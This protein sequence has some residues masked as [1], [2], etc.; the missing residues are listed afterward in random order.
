MDY[1]NAEEAW[2]ALHSLRSNLLLRCG[3]YSALTIPK[4]LLPEGLDLMST[5]QSTD[6][7]SMGARCVNHLTN[8]L[9]TTMFSPSRPFFRAGAGKKTKEQLAKLG[10]TETALQQ[11]LGRIER[12]S[13]ALLDR[14]G[15]RPKLYQTARNLIVTGNSLLVLG[16]ED[17]RTMGLRYYVVKR[18]AAGKVITVVVKEEVKFD[19]LEDAAREELAGR[20]SDDCKVCHYRWIRWEDGKY[21]MDQWVNTYKL[22]EKFSARW[23]E[24]DLPYLA[25]TWDLADESDYGTGLCEDYIG[26]L[27]ATSTLAESV[28]DGAVAGT[29]MRWM[30]TTGYAPRS[31]SRFF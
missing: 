21:V 16:K 19:E 22:S 26:A 25:L 18:N 29:E 28:V 12:E 9:M 5:E 4:V 23:A 1:R 24:A 17:L 3:R 30:V 14:R 8:K 2:S 7:Q 10:M 11:G 6:Y 20:H 15:Q 27:E 31:A 13:T